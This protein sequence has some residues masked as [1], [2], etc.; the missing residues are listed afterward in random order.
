MLSCD[1]NP[2]STAEPRY[3]VHLPNRVCESIAEDDRTASGV[4]TLMY[5]QIDVGRKQPC[6]SRRNK[7]HH[8]RHME[9]NAF[10]IGTFLD[11]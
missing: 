2:Q 10:E 7:S 1:R 4:M 6:I 8:S 3:Q 9:L 5:M 11:S